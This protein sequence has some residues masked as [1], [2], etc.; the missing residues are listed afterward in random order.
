MNTLEQRLREVL[1]LHFD[2][3]FGAPYWLD[4]RGDFSFDPRADIRV[5]QDLAQFGP[6][7]QDV[8]AQRPVEDFIPRSLRHRVPECVTSETGGTTGPPKRA[9]HIY[10]R[11]S[12]RRL[13]PHFSAR[14]T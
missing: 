5:I 12:R 3:D 6:M 9:P 4:R 2:P 7:P 10:R 14:Q 8:L 11:S 13:S 1:A